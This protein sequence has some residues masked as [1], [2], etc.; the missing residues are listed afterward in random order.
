MKRLSDGGGPLRI[1]GARSGHRR[2]HVDVLFGA[3]DDDYPFWLLTVRVN[4]LLFVLCAA[5]VAVS[6][7]SPARLRRA[8]AAR[9]DIWI[10]L[11]WTAIAAGLRFLVAEHNLSDLGGIGYSRILLGYNGHFAAAQLYALV[12][13]RSVRD[14]EHA[15]LLNRLSAT[16]TVPVVYAVCRRLVP[17]T[18]A[19]AFMATA[20][21]ALHPLH[22]LFA[23]TDA[24][25]S[26]SSLLAAVSY[27]LLL[28]AAGDAPPPARALSA[29]GA[30]AGLTLLTQVR[31]E[32]VLLL[33]PAGI[34]AAA[35]RRALASRWLAPAAVCV[36]VFGAIYAVAARR[37]GSS[38]L[39]LNPTHLAECARAA[40]E[41]FG[42][43]IFAMAPVLVGTAAVILDR[44]SGVRRLA[45]LPLL[46]AVSLIAL[47][48]TLPH[49]LA[50]TYSNQV[51][52]LSLI[53]GYGL[54]LLWASP[55][56]GMR[57]IAAGCLL[58]AAA[59]PVLFWP[60]LRQ[61]HLETAEHDVFRDGLASLPAGI[62]RIIV[63]DDEL[64]NRETH[65]T[66]EAVNKYRMIAAAA[67]AGAIE[68]VGM[69][70]FLETRAAFDCS[71]NNC[72]VFRGVPCLGLPH[73]WFAAAAC[74]QVMATATGQAVREE[75][76]TAGSFLDCSIYRGD[77]HRRLCEPL[78]QRVRLGFYRIE[79]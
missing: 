29:L 6:G 43:P 3:G 2:R 53:T 41:M 38:Y 33:V 8:L 40:R 22:V 30:A 76:V 36:I 52:L 65:S 71:R 14:L 66:I 79:R 45:V 32:N 73:Y 60:T 4:I 15:I 17:A 12:Y 49:H 10:A 59:L 9:T 70:R 25:S 19:F 23:A 47:P 67:G 74:A 69:T 78:R 55:W 27:V 48:N 62:D 28:R 56:R 18:R 26:S 37:A 11:A 31:Y 20:V 5:A 24:L 51:L 16:L 64:L 61:R 39:A 77:A 58:W 72:V 63:P 50:R 34:Y 68:L 13:A 42:N 7:L 46:A 44:R 54:A 1:W 21:L 35:R 57:V 75:E